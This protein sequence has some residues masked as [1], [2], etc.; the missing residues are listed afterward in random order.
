M[1][2]RVTPCEAPPVWELEEPRY[3]DQPRYVSFCRIIGR[4]PFATGEICWEK[5]E[6]ELPVI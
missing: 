2:I 4:E 1:T 6:V 5:H 3:L